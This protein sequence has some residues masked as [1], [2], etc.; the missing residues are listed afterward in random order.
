MIATDNEETAYDP[1]RV[2]VVLTAEELTREILYAG[3]DSV[4]TDIAEG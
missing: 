2:E 3:R 1:P 4:E